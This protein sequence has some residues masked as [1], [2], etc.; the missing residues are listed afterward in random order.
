MT[1]LALDELERM[2]LPGLDEPSQIQFTRDGTAITYLDTLA[3]SPLRGVWRHELSGG[4]RRLLIDPESVA[5]DPALATH[6]ELRRQRIHD[7]GEG[8]SA[9]ERAARA[10]VVCALAGGR[11]LVSFDGGAAIPVPGIEGAQAAAI[12]PE[13]ELV[14]WVREGNLFVSGTRGPAQASA[15]RLTDDATDGVTNG[16]AE[17]VAAE[18]LDRFD[19]AWWSTAGDAIVF[20]HVDERQIPAIA[21]PHPGTDP[22]HSE[23]HRYPFPGG[24]NATVELR[25]A[26][27]HDSEEHGTGWHPVPIEIGDGYLARVHAHPLDGW[28]VA[29]L[30]RDQRS[31]AWWRVTA[32][33]Q[34]AELWTEHT[35]P[36]L[37]IDALTRILSDGR[38]LRAT[39]AS[40]Y[41]HLELRDADGSTP[42]H[43]TAG[44]WVV[45]DVAHVD[46]A[47]GE[48]LVVGTADGGLQRH[49]YAVPL[50][51]RHPAE[52]PE[53]LT[54]E[55]G[56][57]EVVVNEDGN[58]WV[59]TFSDRATAPQVVVRTRGA[60]STTVVHRPSTAPDTLGLVVPDL[61]EVAADDGTPL[62]VAL[63]RPRR[64]D[65]APPPA[66][67]WVYGGPHS[68]YVGDCW[69]LTML[70]IRQALVRAGFAVVMADNRGTANR[71]LAF[72]APIAGALGSVE[73]ADQARVVTNLA[74]RGELD[75]ARVGIT[76]ASYGGYLTIMALLRRPDLFRAGVAIAPVVDWDGYDTAYTERYLGTPAANPTAY[77]EASLL[78]R[79]GA[80]RGRLLVM[81]GAIDENV[82]F[83][84]SE[85]LA[86]GL[87]EQGT[88]LELTILPSQRHLVRAPAAML[89]RD[90]R[91]VAF[92][93]RGLGVTL[94]EDLA[95]G[96]PAA[97]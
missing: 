73:L 9:Y 32:D 10:D 17:Y 8:I 39:E 61:L 33:G 26:R 86:A 80:L 5:D 21:I 14:A 76:G 77:R 7:R 30:P 41:R 89:A 88:Q 44:A 74:E 23:V 62:Q 45:T 15:R 63:F 81:H 65:D 58:A 29:V 13:G 43:L 55:P 57:H 94:P 49:L 47:R 96:E 66:V 20:A 85:R 69:E 18:E 83:R 4:A 35:D 48:V 16:L 54:D 27:L 50:D 52:R 71:G 38:V 93:C 59:D 87:A 68:Q 11:C 3:G 6:E 37:N 79:V 25:L 31:L 1:R 46:E 82:H 97:D 19:G 60:S 72:E 70:P 24:P 22:P 56:W 34:A 78:P 64:T 28:L 92:L 53:R 67:V 90:S 40:G 36:W 12:S 42:R 91:P 84:H 2:P 95:T 75:P 51:A